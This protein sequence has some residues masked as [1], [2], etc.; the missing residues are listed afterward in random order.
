MG[1]KQKQD[2]EDED[3]KLP[4]AEPDDD[5][6]AG[7]EIELEAD[8]ADEPGDEG[9]GEPVRKPTRKERRSEDR[10]DAVA[11]AREEARRE[12][13]AEWQRRL[14]EERQRWQQPPP[15]PREEKPPAD[16]HQKR[17]EEIQRQ[18][19]L[20]TYRY[21]NDQSLTPQQRQDLQREF[22]GLSLEVSRLQIAQ[23]IAK[24]QPQQQA[25]QRSPEEA[26]LEAEYPAVFDARE[27]WRRGAALSEYRKL[28]ASGKP[29]GMATAK[30]AC[31]KLLQRLDEMP[32]DAPAPG[33]TEAQRARH[34]STPSRP[35]AGG[36]G[37]D[38][39]IRP[40][41]YQLKLARKL[42]SDVPGIDIE[43][44]VAVIRHAHKVTGGKLF[45]RHE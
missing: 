20:L 9:G 41:K 29:E 5:E 28:V 27:P 13:D 16:E 23:E 36:G 18:A 8:D 39:K 22:Q 21:Q 10:D 12:A 4:A 26:M 14:D 11:R 42:A 7:L 35:V 33:P 3:K 2:A 45:Q 44:D 19:E 25:P 43:D 32:P 6:P 38:S 15:P 1:K 17:I 24:R 37:G 31:K 30:E 34:A 40:T